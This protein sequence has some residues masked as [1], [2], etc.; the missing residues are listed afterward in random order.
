MA[1]VKAN[2]HAISFNKI[3]MLLHQVLHK[4]LGDAAPS[5]GLWQQQ[6]LSDSQQAR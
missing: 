3:T 5:S 2:L 1:C 6:T 4:L